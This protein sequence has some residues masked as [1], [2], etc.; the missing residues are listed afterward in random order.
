MESLRV[1]CFWLIHLSMTSGQHLEI[2]PIASESTESFLK[3]HTLAEGDS[4]TLDFRFVSCFNNNTEPRDLKLRLKE[5]LERN[6]VFP[7]TIYNVSCLH[8]QTSTPG[9]RG[10]I[11]A[12]L[13]GFVTIEIKDLKTN[14]TYAD[15]SVGITRPPEQIQDKVYLYGLMVLIVAITFSFGISLDLQK[16]KKYLK[17]PIA[18]G[19]GMACQFV[20]MPV[21]GYLITLGMTANKSLK[22]GIFASSAAPGGALSNIW[23][24]VLNGDLDLSVTMTFVSTIASIGF[25]PLW[26]YTL[27]QHIIEDESIT[28][29]FSSMFA[30]LALIIVPLI[31]GVLINYFLP[32]I[33]KILNYMQKPVILIII[34]FAGGMSVWTN[35]Y[36]F[37]M[38]LLD[39][40]LSLCTCL[41]P[42]VGGLLGFFIALI[43]RQGKP[44]AVTIGI[45]SAIQNINIA[46]IILKT[47]LPQPWADI[48]S[49]IPI[50][51]I[52]FTFTPFPI[53]WAVQRIY[54]HCR[55][56]TEKEELE[57]IEEIEN[58]NSKSI[59]LSEVQGVDNPNMSKEEI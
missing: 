6:L 33:A 23:C 32:K 52:V 22:L 34:L 41:L 47:S 55:K 16:V 4:Q 37:K 53:F 8:N 29:P 31:I 10:T 7:S 14:D 13:I 11:Y 17:K 38:V 54:L 26:M 56:K 18:P 59:K 5:G 46:T 58:N 51:M 36:A 43:C 3:W 25:V 35:L 57:S 15:Y 12:E 39:W 30:S 44:I 48:S 1:I 19:I 9:A 49:V 45:E 21:I 28:L 42:Y 2:S 24:F 20:L 40:Q 50:V 27:G